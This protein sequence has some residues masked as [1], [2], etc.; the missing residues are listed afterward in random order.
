MKEFG[1][2][3]FTNTR[4]ASAVFLT[5]PTFPV[6]ILCHLLTYAIKYSL[7]DLVKKIL[8]NLYT[9][10]FR[11]QLNMFDIRSPLTADCSAIVLKEEASN[12]LQENVE[13]GVSSG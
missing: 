4:K 9:P 10:N 3:C 1:P 13:C 7:H 8:A 5:M 12:N 2:K 11:L 6:H